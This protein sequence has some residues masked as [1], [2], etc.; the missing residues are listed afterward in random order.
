[1]VDQSHIRSGKAA[2]YKKENIKIHFLGRKRA[3]IRMKRVRRLSDVNRDRVRGKVN[4]LWNESELIVVT[5]LSLKII[6]IIIFN[7][8]VRLLA[9]WIGLP[10]NSFRWW[11]F[12]GRPI[13]ESSNKLLES[14]IHICAFSK[15]LKN[16]FYFPIKQITDKNNIRQ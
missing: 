13:F 10:K 15:H 9:R 8:I 12:V 3:R 5:R 14:H 7:I 1:M 11:L 4:A 16:N 2:S 6:K